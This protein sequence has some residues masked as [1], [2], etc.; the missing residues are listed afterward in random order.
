VA[1]RSQMQF[2]LPLERRMTSLPVTQASPELV[3]A[4]AD[5]LL[6]AL[7]AV[8]SPVTSGRDTRVESEDHI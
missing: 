3:Q 8:V 2:V 6:E 5:L 4:L 7:G 1:N